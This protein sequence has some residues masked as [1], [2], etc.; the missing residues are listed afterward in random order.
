MGFAGTQTG[1]HTNGTDLGGSVATG[2]D[3]GRGDWQVEPNLK[4][5]AAQFWQAGYAQSAGNALYALS[6]APAAV[7]SV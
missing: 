1:G 6:L 7:T 3:L 2:F 4:L 5:T